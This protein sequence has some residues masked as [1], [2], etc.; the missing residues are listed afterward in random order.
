MGPT[1]LTSI[2]IYPGLIC[3][4]GPPGQVYTLGLNK[5]TTVNNTFFFFFLRPIFLWICWGFSHKPQYVLRKWTPMLLA[6]FLSKEPTVLREC[7]VTVWIQPQSFEAQLCWEWN[8]SFGGTSCCLLSMWEVGII[9]LNTTPLCIH[10][11]SGGGLSAETKF[12]LFTTSVCPHLWLLLRYGDELHLEF[13]CINLQ[14]DW[15]Q[16]PRWKF[17]YHIAMIIEIIL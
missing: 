16:Q 11:D 4:L 3:H 12:R 1:W 5:L 10:K 6:S 14:A 15:R 7:I 17:A 2:S 13:N 8:S 9:Y